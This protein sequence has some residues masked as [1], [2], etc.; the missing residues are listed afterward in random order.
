MLVGE[1]ARLADAARV[2]AVRVDGRAV[3]PSASG[4]LVALREATGLDGAA[5]AV[6][7]LAERSRCV[8]LIDTYEQLSPLDGWLRGSFLPDLPECGRTPCRRARHSGDAPA[9]G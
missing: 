7:A 1:F 2:W 3:E 9:L 4:F 6:T 5:S 8:L